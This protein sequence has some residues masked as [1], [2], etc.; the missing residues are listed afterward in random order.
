MKKKKCLII[1]ILTVLF[2]SFNNIYAYGVQSFTPSPLRGQEKNNWCWV[3]VTQTLIE[4]K[5]YWKTQG[6]LAT[7]IFGY[8]KNAAATASQLATAAKW[9]TD[10]TL[11]YD[12]TN[13]SL[14]F[15]GSLSVVSSINN[16]WAVASGLATS[17]GGHMVVLT[18]Y[19]TSNSRVWLQD[20][21]GNT[22]TFPAKGY[23]TWT[24]YNSLITGNYTGTNFS[25]LQYY[26]WIQSVN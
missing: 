15:S 22:N 4:T 17:Y 25:Y 1:L 5:G 26:K 8:E 18:G 16:G 19:D 9:G 10:Y 24:T 12:V 21:Q 3:A 6:Q 23:E 20:P 2:I 11:Q 13:A 14:P 7:C